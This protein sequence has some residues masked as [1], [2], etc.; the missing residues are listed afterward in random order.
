MSEGSDELMVPTGYDDRSA[1]VL[2]WDVVAV[3]VAFEGVADED[4]S[5]AN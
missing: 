4:T 2:P 3:R 5:P 1:D